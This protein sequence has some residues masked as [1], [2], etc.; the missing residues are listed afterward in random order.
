MLRQR[1][2]DLSGQAAKRWV[3]SQIVWNIAVGAITA[4]IFFGPLPPQLLE[5]KKEEDRNRQQFERAEE[6]IEQDRE[7]LRAEE[8]AKKKPDGKITD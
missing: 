8:N 1:G 4:V 2:L 6:P 3:N 7:K 5:G